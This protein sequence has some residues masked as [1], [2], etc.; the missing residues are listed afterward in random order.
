MSRERILIILGV[1]IIL[2]PF[3]GIPLAV[4]S[5]VLP[6]FGIAVI[7]IGVTSHSRIV[8]LARAQ[9]HQL[10]ESI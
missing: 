4:L 10:S 5:W 3:S 6:V 7:T 8:K 9:N 2:S 1:L